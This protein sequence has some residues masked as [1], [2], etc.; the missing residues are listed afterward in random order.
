M[1]L[2]FAENQGKHVKDWFLSFYLQERKEKIQLLTFNCREKFRIS[3]LA[4][5]NNN[6][7]NLSVFYK[8][9]QLLFI[10]Q[11]ISNHIEFFKLKKKVKSLLL[12]SGLGF[13]TCICPTCDSKI[14]KKKLGYGF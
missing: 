1:L 5:P 8:L 3:R 14:K 7:K 9:T 4:L 10:Y 13:Y 2:L 6:K 11:D 12:P